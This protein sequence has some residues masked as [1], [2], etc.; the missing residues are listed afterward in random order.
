MVTT[1]ADQAVIAIENVRLFNEVGAHRELSEFC[2]SRPRPPRCC[3]SFRASPGE[4]EPVFQTMLANATRICEAKFGAVSRS[5]ASFAPSP[6]G[7]PPAYAEPA[8][9]PGHSARPW[10]RSSPIAR[11]KTARPHRR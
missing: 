6:S 9:R 8:A 7:A 2:S 3:G 1:F 4:L 10:T 5:R 11:T